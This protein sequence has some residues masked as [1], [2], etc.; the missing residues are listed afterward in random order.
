MCPQVEKK[1]TFVL[2]YFN[3]PHYST[4]RTCNE[5]CVLNGVHFT[6]D[7]TVIIPIYAIHHNPEHWEEPE[8]FNPDR[9]IIYT[10]T[11]IPLPPLSSFPVAIFHSHFCSEENRVWWHWGVEAVDFHCMKRSIFD[12]LWPVGVTLILSIFFHAPCDYCYLSLSFILGY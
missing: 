8:M 6:K 7:L 2:F 11:T 1:V 9:Y 5:D 3:C 10:T 12:S 4:F